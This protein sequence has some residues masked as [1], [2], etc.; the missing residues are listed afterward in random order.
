MMNRTTLAVAALLVALAA[1]PR[2]PE[3]RDHEAARRAAGIAARPKTPAGLPHALPPRPF[4][5][6]PTETLFDP[7]RT[8]CSR[9]THGAGAEALRPPARNQEEKDMSLRR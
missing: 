8:A 4:P 6:F 2:G 5:T 3:E 7:A 1:R 9:K